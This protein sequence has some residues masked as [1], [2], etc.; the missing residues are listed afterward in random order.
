LIP[1]LGAVASTQPE[2]VVQVL[3][4]VNLEPL[5]TAF[6]LSGVPNFDKNA[7]IG[8][9]ATVRVRVI[10]R[11]NSIGGRRRFQTKVIGGTAGL[12]FDARGRLLPLGSTTTARAAQMPLWVSEAT[13]DEILEIDPR[14]M[15]EAQIETTQVE[16][17]KNGRKAREPER[18]ERRERRGLFGRR[19]QK[20]AAEEAPL[21]MDN[22]TDEEADDPLKELRDASLS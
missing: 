22:L 9:T 7:P 5:G 12:I 13:G 16:S 1:A 15:A 18:K 4:G 11:G 14:L 20:A 6:S 21:D 2:A 10:G 8:Q 3:D 17:G 19:R